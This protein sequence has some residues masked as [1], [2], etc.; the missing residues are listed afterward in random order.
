[1]QFQTLCV[2]VC[3]LSITCCSKESAQLATSDAS[4]Q[5]KD[6]VLQGC[7]E[8]WDRRISRLTPV[9]RD[10]FANDGILVGG[11]ETEAY[12]LISTKIVPDCKSRIEIGAFCGGYTRIRPFR[13]T[14]S[15]LSGTLSK[16]LL[17]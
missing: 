5:S 3:F 6:S 17:P 4:V 16:L 1:M 9:Q 14:W 10:Q 8:E 2:L 12:F 13:K 7:D 11:S 15:M